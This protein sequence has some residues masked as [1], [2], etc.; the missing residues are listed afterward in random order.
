MKLLPGEMV[1]R[2]PHCA[3]ASDCRKALG[4]VHRLGIGEDARGHTPTGVQDVRG[5]Q[6]RTTTRFSLA[7][8]PRRRPDEDLVQ[9]HRGQREEKRDPV[10]LRR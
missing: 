8:G 3:A 1:E 10:T 7:H 2:T 9:R 4:Q 5:M 6:L